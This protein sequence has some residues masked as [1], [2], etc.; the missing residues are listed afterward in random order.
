MKYVFS[1]IAA[2]LLLTSIANAA[3]IAQPNVVD[4][5]KKQITFIY[6]H[7]SND[8]AGK[9]RLEFRRH[10]Y[11]QANEMHPYLMNAFNNDELAKKTLLKSG[12]KQINP[13]PQV[14]FWGDKSFNEVSALD[15]KLSA[16]T[17]F[18]PKLPQ[19][20]RSAFAHCLHD[21]VW[22]QK[23][24]NMALII[25]E[26]DKKVKAETAKGHEVVLL[27]YSAGS[28]ITYEYFLNKFISL[29]PAELITDKKYDELRKKLNTKKIEPTCFDA[30][31]EANIVT[32]EIS[33]RYKLNPDKDIVV[34]NYP[35]LNE[36]TK[37]ACIQ[38]GDVA[39]VI[40]FA[41]PLSLFYS[42]ISAE[43][44]D[45]NFISKLMYKHILETDTFWLTVNYMEDPLGFPSSKNL[46]RAQ[47]NDF[48]DFTITPK[49]GFVY[50]KSDVRAYRSFISAHLSYW[51]T[52]KRFS[53]AVIK[54]YNAGYKNM[55]SKTDNL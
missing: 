35:L 7:G 42:D 27:G 31:H 46:T 28:F 54:A 18:S 13:E 21:A 39:G 11:K 55:Y 24:T 19:I 29:D 50:D 47:L 38:D 33:G 20:V 32:L 3:Q 43:K 9:N 53:N 17:L 40:N 52:Q 49:G 25:D 5:N 12:Q 14:F 45:L 8:Y 2:C 4:E 16:V 34:K 23:Y 36:K 26:L 15:E 44:S 22:V 48:S 1:F 51:D 41:S 30:L 6:V 10:F 37:T